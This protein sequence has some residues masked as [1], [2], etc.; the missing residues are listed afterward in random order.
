MSNNA[1]DREVILS[2]RHVDISFDTGNKKKKFVAVPVNVERLVY[3]HVSS[4]LRSFSYVHQYFIFD[5][6]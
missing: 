3:R 5:T 1:A 6:S 4:P 2:I